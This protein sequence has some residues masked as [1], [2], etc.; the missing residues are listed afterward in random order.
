MVTSRQLETSE[1]CFVIFFS[2]FSHVLYLLN[3]NTFVSAGG[4]R[5]HSIMDCILMY[6]KW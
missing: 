1:F 6:V 3:G 5:T 2:Y 4:K